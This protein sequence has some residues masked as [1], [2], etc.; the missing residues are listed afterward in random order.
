MESSSAYVDNL[1]SPGRFCFVP[2]LP[3]FFFGPSFRVLV[4]YHL[5]RGRMLLH[6]AFGINS[7]KGATTYVKTMVHRKGAMIIY[8]LK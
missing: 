4:T 2:V 8:V 3:V 6:D 5:E 7:V 1:V